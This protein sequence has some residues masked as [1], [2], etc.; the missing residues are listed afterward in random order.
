MGRRELLSFLWF[1]GRFKERERKQEDAPIFVKSPFHFTSKVGCRGKETASPREV[2]KV[3]L[4][5]RDQ[6]LNNII[7]ISFKFLFS[8]SFFTPIKQEEGTSQPLNGI[9]FPSLLFSIEPILPTNHGMKDFSFRVLHSSIHNGVVQ[10]P[11]IGIHLV[12]LKHCLDSLDLRETGTAENNGDN[13]VI[14]QVTSIVFGCWFSLR[15]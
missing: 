8:S 13:E 14:M 3:P 12:V 5:W 1:E 9:Q 11:S 2:A 4:K 7:L 15:T 10:K 6:L